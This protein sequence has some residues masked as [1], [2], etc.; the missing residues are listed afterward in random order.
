MSH[1]NCLVYA[2]HKSGFCFLIDSVA[3]MNHSCC[4]N[5]IV[6]YKGTL[7]EVRAVQEIYPGEEV[8]VQWA[9]AAVKGHCRQTRAVI[10]CQYWLWV[11]LV[12]DLTW[13]PSLELS[14][15][16]AIS[17]FSQEETGK[18]TFKLHFWQRFQ[19]MHG[20]RR[21]PKWPD[22][23]FWLSLESFIPIVKQLIQKF[24][25]VLLSPSSK[26]IT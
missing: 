2:I 4:P 8:S 22:W 14:L 6:T 24:V 12:N 15:D 10:S 3:L 11:I 13:N 5:V 26:G 20:E 7:A 9:Q 19:E 23:K 18:T 16:L 25:P 1:L 17:F 21:L